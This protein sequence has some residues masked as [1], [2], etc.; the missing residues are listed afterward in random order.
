MKIATDPTVPPEGAELAEFVRMAV[1]NYAE[2]RHHRRNLAQVSLE[3]TT[4]IALGIGDTELAAAL[5][6]VSAWRVAGRHQELFEV[7]WRVTGLADL[8]PLR[9]EPQAERRQYLG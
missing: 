6:L 1:R 5:V 9:A 7:L 3:E 2:N 8:K 4:E